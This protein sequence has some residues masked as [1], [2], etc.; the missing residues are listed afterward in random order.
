MLRDMISVESSGGTYM[1][2]KELLDA[3]RYKSE[4]V[5]IDFKSAQY[6]FVAGNEQE[7]S[8]LLKPLNPTKQLSIV[9]SE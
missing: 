5:D 8:E 1:S 6:R 7:K 3:L 9:Q 2:V 4:G